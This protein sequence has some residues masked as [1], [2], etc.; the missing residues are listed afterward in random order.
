VEAV[1]EAVVERSY[2]DPNGDQEDDAGIE[3]VK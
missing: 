2:D 1:Q 3:G